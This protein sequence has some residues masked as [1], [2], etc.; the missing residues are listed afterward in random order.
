MSR[1][2]HKLM[3]SSGSKGYEIESSLMFD[4]GSNSQLYRTPGSA[5]NLNTFTISFWLKRTDLGYNNSNLEIIYSGANGNSGSSDYGIIY[6]DSTDRLGF[7]HNS[8]TIALTNRYFS[9]ISAWYH[10]Y[11]K[12]DSTQ[13]TASNRWA[14][15]VNGVQETSMNENNNPSQNTDSAFTNNVTLTLGSLATSTS[16][17]FG[18][19]LADFHLIDGTI[20]PVTDF[21]ET[22]S[23]TGQ[24]IPKEYTGGSYGTTGFYLPFKK[25]DRYS[26]YFNA[27]ASSGILTADHADFAVGSGDFTIECWFYVDAYAGNYRRVFGKSSSTG[28]NAHTE[29]QVDIDS[30]NKPV[31]YVYNDGGSSYLTLQSASAITD[32]KWHHVALVRNGS[33]FNLYVDGTSVANATSSMTVNDSTYKFGIGRVGEYGS[34]IFKGWISNLRFVKGTAVYTSNFTPS[35]SPLTAITNTKLLCCQDAIITTENSGTSKT[36]EVT[37]AQVKTEQMSPFQFD[38]YDDH[39][40]QNNHYQAYNLTVN[41]VMLDSPTS[42][43]CTV[44]RRDSSQNLTT[45][46]GNTKFHAS[47]TNRVCIRGTFGVTSGKWYYE[48]TD[49]AS[50]SGSVGVVNA[51][52]TSLVS[53]GMVGNSS[54]GWAVNNDGAKENGNSET[55]SYMAS[56]TTGDVIGVALNMDDGEITFYKNGSSAGVAFNN[57][58]GKGAIFPAVCTGSH[59]GNFDTLNFGQ[60][61]FAHTPP[62]GYKAWNTSNLPDPA[63]K[64]PGEHFN[65]VLYTGSDDDAVSQNVTGVGHQ[66]DLV[67]IKRR[68]LETHHVLTDAVRGATKVLNSNQTVAEVDDTYGVT[69]FGSDGFTVREQ[70]SAGGQTNTGTLVSWNWKANGSGGANNSGDINATVSANTTAGFSIVSW[71]GDGSNGNTVAHGL[72]KEP[73]AIFYK[74]RDAT[75]HWYMVTKEIDGSQDYLALSSTTFAAASESYGNP[76]TSTISNW[77]WGANAIIAYC[78]AEIEGFSK[79]GSYSGTGSSNGPFIPTGFKPAWTMIKRTDAANSWIISDSKITPSNLIDDYLAADLAQAESSTSAVG[80]D[81]LSNGFKIRNSANAMNNSSG[82]YFYMAFAEAPFK[83]ATAR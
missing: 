40:G 66:P 68:N 62:T 14:I 76:T 55:A 64:N 48:Y 27:H 22:N 29:Y 44:N 16:Y 39:S 78:F 71:T 75:S 19:Y 54:F 9:D 24:W 6:F 50:S 12:Y 61:D 2:A 57:L 49:G 65:T 80:I 15:Y 21:G 25:N 28:A 38:W 5:G 69:A 60:M 67:W 79:I 63:I 52:A 83:Y 30:N 77:T 47:D 72:G 33:A 70:A 35:T 4:R 17:P 74:N 3:A 8:S 51:S 45:S 31:A 58:S 1:T 73:Q 18:G 11:I 81:F 42:N 53:D 13:G 82:T 59:S 32:S 34:Q 20:K 23:D 26:P 56:F 7:Y 36:L 46:Q 10:I 41:D 43:Y 37:A